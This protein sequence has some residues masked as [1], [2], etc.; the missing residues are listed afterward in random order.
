LRP[1]Y[2]PSSKVLPVSRSLSDILH[3]H[4]QLATNP[5]VDHFSSSKL[6]SLVGDH[7]NIHLPHSYDNRHENIHAI[8]KDRRFQFDQHI[9]PDPSL[10]VDCGLNSTLFA[11]YFPH[12]DERLK[13]HLLMTTMSAPTSPPSASAD[14]STKTIS[15]PAAVAAATTA[16]SVLKNSFTSLSSFLI[17]Q[18]QASL[19][20]NIPESKLYNAYG[21]FSSADLMHKLK[22]PFNFDH[23]RPHS[24]IQ[25]KHN[26]YDLCNHSSNKI[27]RMSNVQ[28]C[29]NKN[30]SQI[31][32]SMQPVSAAPVHKRIYSF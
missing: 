31:F 17:A 21:A 3:I 30:K 24:L 22:T 8:K 28:H 5:K 18:D 10:P 16:S 29:P 13:T 12:A 14:C 23:H 15:T 11:E 25:D 2:G 32:G 6:A 26:L 7:Q 4:S 9:K 1:N 20:S 27:K 19:S